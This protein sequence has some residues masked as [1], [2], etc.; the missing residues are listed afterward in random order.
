M[1]HS[2]RL[3]PLRVENSSLL[4]ALGPNNITLYGN[5]GNNAVL[6]G[7]VHCVRRIVKFYNYS[8]IKRHKISLTILCNANLFAHAK[9]GLYYITNPQN[10]LFPTRNHTTHWH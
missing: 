10:V 9:F 5:V 6:Y 1:H 8:M 2:K 4:L 7:V 3:N